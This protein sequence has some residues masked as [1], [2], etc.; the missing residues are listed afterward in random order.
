MVPSTRSG[1]GIQLI[2]SQIGISEDQDRSFRQT[3]SV[4]PMSWNPSS[5]ENS[6]PDPNGRDLNSSAISVMARWGN[7]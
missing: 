3:A 6:Q 5:H 7:H 4:A 2:A 1:I